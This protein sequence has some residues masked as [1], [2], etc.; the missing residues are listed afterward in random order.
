MS[1]EYCEHCDNQIKRL[2]FDFDGEIYAQ[3]REGK[4]LDYPA[5]LAVGA[6]EGVI[7]FGINYCPWCG[8]DLK[9]A[10]D[11]KPRT[12]ED[13]IYDIA[14]NSVEMGYYASGI[15]RI[16]GINADVLKDGVEQHMDEIRDLLGIA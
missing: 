7:N 1:N 3:V 12:L 2:F 10:A 14:I 13:V 6:I 16:L 4:T 15:P 9:A 8:R 5:V 11:V